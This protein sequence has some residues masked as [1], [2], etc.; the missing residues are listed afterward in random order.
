MQAVAERDIRTLLSEFTV[1]DVNS[2][3][4][5]S[6]DVIWA[7]NRGTY[8]KTIAIC[9]TKRMISL[10]S[11]AIFVVEQTVQAAEQWQLNSKSA[12]TMDIPCMFP[13]IFHFIVQFMSTVRPN[14]EAILKLRT[15]NFVLHHMSVGFA[16]HI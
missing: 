10:N 2:C 5:F 12:Q 6:D 16:F 1:L 7:I 4:C 8:A 9:V 13:T 15:P 3:L 14:F 11:P